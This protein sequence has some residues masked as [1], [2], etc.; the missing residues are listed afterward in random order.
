MDASMLSMFFFSTKR[1]TLDRVSALVF[2]LLFVQFE[3]L[4]EFLIFFQTFV[5]CDELR[6]SIS[7]KYVSLFHS[8]Q[9]VFWHSIS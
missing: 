4:F 5:T 1:F 6:I 8:T 2:A 9:L 3:I 7:A